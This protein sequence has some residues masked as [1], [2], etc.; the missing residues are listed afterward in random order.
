[1][2]F[3]GHALGRPKIDRVILRIMSDEN[4]VLSNLLAENVDLATDLTLRYEHGKVLEDSWEASKRGVVQLYRGTFNYTMAQFRRDFQRVPALFDARVRKAL[5][6]AIDRQALNEGLFDGRGFMAETNIPDNAR[7][8]P[9][10]KRSLVRYAYDPRRTEQFMAEAGFVK[11]Q[12]GFFSA[13]NGERFRP[14]FFTIQSPLF[15]RQQA[16]MAESWSRAGIDTNLLIMGAAQLRNFEAALTFSGLS[17]RLTGGGEAS[18]PM[19][20]TAQIGSPANRWLGSNRGGWNS[21]EFDQLFDLYLTTLD[22][23]ERDRQ[24]IAMMQL[25]SEQ[26][27]VFALYFNIDV[28]GHL[29]K[30]LGPAVGDIERLQLWNIHEWELR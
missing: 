3:D 21:P 23:S 7:Y 16:I 8:Y 27:P 4:A 10:L 13:V 26:L 19:F 1:V 30:V 14:D 12:S 17:T 15:E 24:V 20:T 22:R 25:T 2:A 18:L 6:H 11:D 28:L 29:S 5:A 9:Q